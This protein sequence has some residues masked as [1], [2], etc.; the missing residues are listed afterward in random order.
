[1]K[2]KTMLLTGALLAA[3]GAAWADCAFENTTPIKSLS[4][5]FEAWKAVTDAMAECG[6][7]EASLD[8]EFREKQP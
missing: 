5:G 6:N 4:A 2:L 1:M 8:Q 7:F 3:S